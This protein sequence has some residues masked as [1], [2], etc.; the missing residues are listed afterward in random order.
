MCR[1]GDR[2][3]HDI[4]E[5][6]EAYTEELQSAQEEMLS[7]NEEMRSLN[8]EL[9]SSRQE[10]QTTVRELT[11]ANREL[12]ESREKQDK[13]REY[14]ERV[15]AHLRE[16]FVVLEKDFS[17]KAANASYFSRFGVTKRE[18]VGKPFFEVHNRMWGISEL[19]SR[20]QEVLPLK[21]RIRDKEIRIKSSMGEERSFLFNAR[22]II[23]EKELSDSI[24]LSIKDITHEKGPKA[25]NS[26]QHPS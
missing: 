15:L 9:E 23:D 21:K 7:S 10:L 1:R 18:T 8:E 19:R 5:E 20:L 22:E 16:P 24:L 12:Q 3:E 17:I 2:G 25:E 6:H 4:L 11:L 26:S 13:E 14:L